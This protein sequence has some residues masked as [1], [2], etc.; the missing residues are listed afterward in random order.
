MPSNLTATPISATTIRLQWTDNSANENGFTVVNG[1]TSRNA[2]ANTTTYDWDGLA[3]ATYTCFKVRSYNSSGA[4]AYDPA[5]Q[6]DWI[7]ATSLSGTGP[8]APTDLL[9]APVNSTTIRVAWTDNSTDESGFTITNGAASRNVGANTTT[10]YWDGLAPNTY[11][12]FKVR[13]FNAAG[14]SAY[15]PAAQQDWVCATTPPNPT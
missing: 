4:S 9:A 8:A 10:Y 13:S 12:C 14:V 6:Q 5:A 3:P 7:C 11:M 1:A 15:D 2:G